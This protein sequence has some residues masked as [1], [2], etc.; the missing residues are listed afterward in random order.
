MSHHGYQI[1]SYLLSVLYSFISGTYIGV[2][3][4]HENAELQN[5]MDNDIMILNIHYSVLKETYFM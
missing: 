5:Y 3:H 1:G 2:A 4:S